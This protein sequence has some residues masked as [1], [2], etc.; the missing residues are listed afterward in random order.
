MSND[1]LI[2]SGRYPVTKFS[3]AENHKAYANKFGYKYSNCSWPGKYRNPYFNKIEYI[4][5]HFEKYEYIFWIDDDAFFIDF[6]FDISSLIPKNDAL[7]TICT[8]PDYKKIWTYISS[9]QFMIRCCEETRGFLN[10]VLSSDLDLIKSWWDESKYGYFTGGDQDAMVYL[11][12]VKYKEILDIRNY[13]LFNSRI[14]DLNRNEEVR[15]LH[16]TGVEKEKLK[17]LKKAKI[18][19]KR[20]DN[21]IPN[22]YSNCLYTYKKKPFISRVFNKIISV[23]DLYLLY[24]KNDLNTH[25]FEAILQGYSKFFD[26]IFN[27]CMYVKDNCEYMCFRGKNT[28]GIR[29]YLHVSG[30]NLIDLTE[31]VSSFGIDKCSDPKFF[32]HKNEVFI[33]FNTG[34]VTNSENDIYIM[35]VSEKLGTPLKCNYNNRSRIEKNWG[36]WSNK[37]RLFCIYSVTPLQ[38][39]EVV[40]WDEKNV[41]LENVLVTE[42][43]GF[44]SELTIGTQPLNFDNKLYFF[45]HKKYFSYFKRLYIGKLI[46]LQLDVN[47]KC[48]FIKRKNISNYTFFHDLKSLLGSKIKLNKN[49]LSCTYFSSL[50]YYEGEVYVGYG[51]NDV[52]AKVRKVS[53]VL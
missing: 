25:K 36:F 43:D 31:H 27:P 37:D 46:S 34:Y 11:S 23:A 52:Q 18:I 39:L 10:E 7:I 53:E 21:L 50:F 49:L 51:V 41:N 48:I 6:D 15:L 13:Q 32:T 28:G 12:K 42:H 14:E 1:I 29:S 19:L 16:F 20:E 4:L 30:R 38:F 3:S 33:T 24:D 22:Q 40:S 47:E 44:D 26:L 8:S 17:A 35:S 45:A 9:G 2:V 5:E